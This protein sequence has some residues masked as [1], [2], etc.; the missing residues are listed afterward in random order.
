MDAVSGAPK[1]IGLNRNS[2]GEVHDSVDCYI[3]SEIPVV[4]HSVFERVEWVPKLNSD[5][6]VNL[7]SI[8]VVLNSR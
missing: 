8:D 3:P 5:S 4:S 2:C 7:V 6:A 1:T